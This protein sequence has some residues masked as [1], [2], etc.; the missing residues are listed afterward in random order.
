MTTIPAL[1]DSQHKYVT[2][3]ELL[4]WQFSQQESPQILVADE[5]QRRSVIE[6]CEG[7]G[8]PVENASIYL[9]GEASLD[10]LVP[11]EIS[12]WLGAA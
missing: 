11:V 4:A 3:R 1:P 9:K 12:P 8:L 2:M 6:M 7:L 10:N 5:A